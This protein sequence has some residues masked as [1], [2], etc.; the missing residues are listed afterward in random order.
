[1][2]QKLN[3]FAAENMENIRL[4]IEEESQH[5]FKFWKKNNFSPKLLE[6][7]VKKEEEGKDEKKK[8]KKSI[9]L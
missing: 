4:K 9:S 5:F 7:T 8:Q 2:W 1:M 3:S 6:G